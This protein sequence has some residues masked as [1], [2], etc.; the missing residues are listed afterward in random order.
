MARTVT[1]GT[2]VTRCK[3]RADMEG[4]SF[5]S[6]TEWKTLISLQYAELYALLAETGMR[7]FETEADISTTGGSVYSLPSDHLSTVG[8]D[9]LINDAGERQAATR[10]DG[11]GA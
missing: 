1:L 5:I 11:A 2:L 4:Q 8:I 3:Q 9:Y 10:A 7:Y 6:D